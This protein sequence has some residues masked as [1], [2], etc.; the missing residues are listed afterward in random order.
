MLDAGLLPLRKYQI[1]AG[2]FLT[3]GLTQSKNTAGVNLV[4]RI[5]SARD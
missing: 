5:I 3:M 2:S 1:F 4:G